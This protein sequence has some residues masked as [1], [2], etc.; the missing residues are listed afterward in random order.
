MSWDGNVIVVIID[1]A[2]PVEEA[3]LGTPLHLTPDVTFSERTRVY[4][5]STTAKSDSEIGTTALAAVEAHFAQPLHTSEIKLGRREPDVAM[6]VTFTIDTGV[7]ENDEYNIT[8]NS[9]SGGDVTAGVTPTPDTVATAMRAVLTTVLAG[10]PVSVGGTGADVVITSTTAGLAFTYTSSYTATGGGTSGITTVVTTPNGNVSTELDAVLLEDSD[11]YGLTLASRDDTDIA[12]GAAWTES[13]PIK[14]ALFQSSTADV[15]TATTPNVLDDLK[16]LGYKRT[17]YAWHHDD[18]QYLDVAWMGFTLQAD[19]DLKT[20]I[21]AYKELSGVSLKSPRLTP[22]EYN[23]IDNNNGNR[24]A[25]FGGRPKTGQGVTVS[26]ERID[27]VTTKDW[28][29]VS[30]TA[31]WT[32]VLVDASQRNSKIAYTDQG[33]RAFAAAGTAVNDRGVA[34]GHFAP[35]STTSTVVPVAQVP[36]AKRADRIV[37]PRASAV[38]ADAAEK[39]EAEGSITSQQI[40]AG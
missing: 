36:P 32:Q 31:A 38:Y 13:A 40:T 11:W 26:G 27:R 25:V 8:I 33:L 1:D 22:T 17:A 15:L 12:Y 34:A 9:V 18:T 6:V 28:W 14:L 2:L 23:N 39:V 19:P 3:N 30:L 10:E 4:T 37:L 21:W 16:S 5:S 20:T 29:D 35:G 24:Y 7:L